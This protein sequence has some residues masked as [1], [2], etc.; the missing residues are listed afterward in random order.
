MVEVTTNVLLI[1]RALLDVDDH[2]RYGYELMH[3]TGLKAASMYQALHRMQDE[4]WLTSYLEEGDPRQLGRKKRR[5]Y[6]L[7]E[8]GE[9]LART[10]LRVWA[11]RLR[12]ISAA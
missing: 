5:Y 6:E 3:I 8:R 4:G 1:S 9:Y 11:E 2:R 10:H 7:T 12:N